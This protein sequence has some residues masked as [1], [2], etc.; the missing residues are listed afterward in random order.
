MP[1]RIKKKSISSTSEGRSDQCLTT[2][3]LTC[4]KWTFPD[5]GGGGR[6]HPNM[7][8]FM[9]TFFN[10]KNNCYIIMCILLVLFY[11]RLVCT[12]RTAI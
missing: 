4:R 1:R 9:N 10:F 3:A 11:I 2:G 12:V 5:D 7:S 6:R 8:D